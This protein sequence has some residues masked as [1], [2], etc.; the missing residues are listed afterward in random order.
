[1]KHKFKPNIKIY[2]TKAGLGNVSLVGIGFTA[3]CYSLCD[4]KNII[5]D[6]EH[7]HFKLEWD[8]SNTQA[9]F[10]ALVENVK[11]V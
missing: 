6:K 11:I 8:S 3:N 9:Y 4:I 10:W 1:M 2:V 5:P 7:V